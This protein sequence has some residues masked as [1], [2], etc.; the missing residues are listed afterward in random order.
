MDE[1]LI[2]TPNHEWLVARARARGLTDQQIV[3]MICWGSTYT[4]VRKLAKDWAPY[5]DM[6]PAEFVRYARPPKRRGNA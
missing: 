4:D 2:Y 6:T 5:L 1:H 3:R